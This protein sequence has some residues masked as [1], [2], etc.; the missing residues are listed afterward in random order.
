MRCYQ[1]DDDSLLLHANANAMME[2]IKV[3]VAWHG[4]AWHGIR[5]VGNGL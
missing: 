5:I 2:R 3:V 1:A 4:M